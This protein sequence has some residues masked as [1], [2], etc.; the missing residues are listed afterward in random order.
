MAKSAA[1]RSL[2]RH[3]EAIVHARQACQFPDISFLPYVIL[4]AALAEGGKKSEAQAAVEKAMQLQ[5]AV[6]ISFIRRNFVGINETYLK[7]L[8]DSLRKAGV[9]E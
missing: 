3:D 9:P 8:C 1:L 4:A 2:G 5:P 7:N 6:S